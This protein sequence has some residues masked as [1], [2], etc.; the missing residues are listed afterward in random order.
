MEKK[1]TRFYNELLQKT[2]VSVKAKLNYINDL[3]V[4]L[5]L[6]ARLKNIVYGNDKTNIDDLRSD[7]EVFYAASE[8]RQTCFAD[9]SLVDIAFYMDNKRCI[10]HTHGID[11][12]SY[13]LN[14][15]YS[16]KQVTFRSIL[17][18]SKIWNDLHIMKPTTLL[19]NDKNTKVI[20]F[21][22]TSSV[23]Y[24]SDAGIML[25]AKPEMFDDILYAPGSASNLPMLIVDKDNTIISGNLPDAKYRIDYSFYDGKI[26]R[27][28]T[29]VGKYTVYSSGI[30]N[31]PWKLII[32]VPDSSLTFFKSYSLPFFISIIIF[33]V[34]G[35]LLSVFLS[36]KNYKPIRNIVDSIEKDSKFRQ[37]SAVLD[38]NDYVFI[39]NNMFKMNEKIQQL[40]AKVECYRELLD[41]CLISKLLTQNL[42]KS[43]E[44]EEIRDELELTD[45]NPVFLVVAYEISCLQ[46]NSNNIPNNE[47][48]SDSICK[49]IME[50]LDSNTLKLSHFKVYPSKNTLL[51]NWIVDSFQTEQEAMINNIISILYSIKISLSYEKVIHTIFGVGSP[52]NSLNEISRS[53]V[54]ACEALSY[55]ILNGSDWIVRFEEILTMNTQPFYYPLE[56][57]IDL[58]NALK[59]G[60]TLKIESI[61]DLIL[62][63][64]MN[65]RILDIFSCKCLYNVLY[66]TL[67][68]GMKLLDNEYINNKVIPEDCKRSIE[69]MIALLKNTFTKAIYEKGDSNESIIIN[70]ILEFIDENSLNPELSL[71]YLAGK[72]NISPFSISKFFNRDLNISFH[73]HVNKKRIAHA[74]KLLKESSFNITEIGNL[75]GFSNENTFIRVF[76]RYEGIT[77]GQ[78]KNINL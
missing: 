60:N 38:K 70:R 46:A 6:N 36:L 54:D 59:I 34:A 67:I 37:E 47:S 52:V 57:E 27:I 29:T 32:F 44:Y 78:Y 64:N 33:I 7:L 45:E 49:I 61:L 26:K 65:N 41:R 10:I 4:F 24:N 2:L 25:F 14:K 13:F 68:K 17:Q 21:I 73:E 58:L 22:K 71:D 19:L 20:T 3:S 12:S 55:G 56:L 39:E 72:L 63:E 77:P 43:S 23:N 9:K 8:L 42:L 76:K 15:L 5:L 75:C 74:L 40:Q 11:E 35:I 1:D 69:G 31:I 16:D 51:F 66:A 18:S 50:Q 48:I 62:E 53:Y 28:R 30:D